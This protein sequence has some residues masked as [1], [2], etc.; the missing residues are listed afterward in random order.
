M[1][2]FLFCSFLSLIWW[3]VVFPVHYFN[4]LNLIAGIDEFSLLT[5][6]CSLQHTATKL[7]VS[8][9]ASA[10]PGLPKPENP[11]QWLKGPWKFFLAVMGYSLCIQLLGLCYHVC[12]NLSAESAEKLCHLFEVSLT[13]FPN[14]RWPWMIRIRDDKEGCGYAMGSISRCKIC[15]SEAEKQ[16]G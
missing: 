2:V 4:M 10:G 13:L 11:L 15:T 3:V 16:E 5:T 9:A 1:S 14:P 7:A 6:L 12:P 8:T